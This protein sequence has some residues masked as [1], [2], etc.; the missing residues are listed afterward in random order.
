MQQSPLGGSHRAADV[1]LGLYMSMLS[2]CKPAA[3]K[4]AAAFAVLLLPRV[5]L[6]LLLHTFCVVR[7]ALVV[8]RLTPVLF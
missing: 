5:L 4:P 8:S 3:C 1:L 7:L 6:L 2:A